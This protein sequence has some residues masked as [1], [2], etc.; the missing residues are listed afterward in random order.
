MQAYGRWTKLA[1][2]EPGHVTI[3]VTDYA[4]GERLSLPSVN[5]QLAIV[6]SELPIRQ[7]QPGAT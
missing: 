1:T 7:N 3:N 5:D 6:D 4:V 2:E